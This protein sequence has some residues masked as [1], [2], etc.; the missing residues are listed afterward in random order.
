MTEKRMNVFECYLSLW[1]AA[2]MILGVL[3]GKR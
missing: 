2:C 1:V 3:I